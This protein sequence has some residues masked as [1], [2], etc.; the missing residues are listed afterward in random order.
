M[1]DDK[2]RWIFPNDPDPEVQLAIEKMVHELGTNDQYTVDD[3]IGIAGW[4]IGI[5]ADLSGVRRA[6]NSEVQWLSEVFDGRHWDA[7]FTDTLIPQNGQSEYPMLFEL[8]DI[9]EDVNFEDFE[10]ECL[11]NECMLAKDVIKSAKGQE[12][13]NLLIRACDLAIASK[14]A[15]HLDSP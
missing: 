9:Y 5:V 11:R 15:L 1:Q 3:A 6:D 10:V 14:M 12:G 7:I 8:K 4:S 2:I 13:L